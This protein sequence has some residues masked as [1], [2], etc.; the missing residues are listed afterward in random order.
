RQGAYRHHSHH[1]AA[2]RPAGHRR[3]H[4]AAVHPGDPRARLIAVSLHQRHDGHGRASARLLRRRQ[5][6]KGGRLQPCADATA[7]PRDRRRRL[8]VPRAQRR[9]ERWARG[10]MSINVRR[11][12]AMKSIL[13]ALGLAAVIALPA[14]AQDFG[15]PELIAAAKKEGRLVYYTANFAE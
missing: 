9:G 6:R 12:V 3:R 8:V 5:Y 7:P 15:P 13:T 1:R 4:D 10:L 14:A 2:A 11:N